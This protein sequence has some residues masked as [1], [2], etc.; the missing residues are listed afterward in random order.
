MN[1]RE[2]SSVN[3]QRALR[4]HPNGIDEWSPSDWMV[5]L[6][7]E[8]GELANVM[9]KL[10]RIRDGIA[11]NKETEEELKAALAKEIGDIPPYLDL[12]AQRYNLDVSSCTINKFNDVS[13]RMGFP[14]RLSTR[15]IDQDNRLKLISE[16][17]ESA[18]T[19]RTYEGLMEYV[20]EIEKLAGGQG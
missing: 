8:V 20:K 15:S 6:V 18:N 10:N 17:C 4:W 2:F 12:L 14:E 13:K 11:G 7:G 1:L 3:L 16:L 19:T 9:K 5:A